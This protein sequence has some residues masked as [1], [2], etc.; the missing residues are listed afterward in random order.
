MG[1]LGM[2]FRALVGNPKRLKRAK[3]CDFALFNIV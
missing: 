1:G 2:G 3:E